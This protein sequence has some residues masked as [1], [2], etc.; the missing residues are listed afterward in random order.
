VVVGKPAREIRKR[1]G[2]ELIRLLL[3]FKWWDK[4]I[5][6][7]NQLIPILT[8]SDLEKVEAEI[9]ERLNNSSN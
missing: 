2:D 7:I 6:E 9:T 8:S 5:E 3:S 1:F 4:N